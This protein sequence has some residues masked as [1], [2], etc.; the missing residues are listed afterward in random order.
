MGLILG[1][2]N[3]IFRGEYG[4]ITG[5]PP[6]ASVPEIQAIHHLFVQIYI[7]LVVS[8]NV[9]SYWHVFKVD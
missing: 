4:K 9:P 8:P 3:N 1:S 2:F 6:L 7:L 5:K